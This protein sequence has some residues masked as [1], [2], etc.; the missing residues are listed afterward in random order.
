M[1]DRVIDALEVVEIDEE[2]RELDALAA[3]ARNNVLEVLVQQ[4][5]VRQ[6]R[7]AVLIGEGANLLVGLLELAQRI[8]TGSGLRLELRVRRRELPRS[9]VDLGRELV[10][11]ERREP[12]E[13]PALAQSVS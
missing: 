7:E 13:L 11:L 3:A 2:H 10:E 1:S 5:P 9:L 8:L 4:P 6:A 12:R